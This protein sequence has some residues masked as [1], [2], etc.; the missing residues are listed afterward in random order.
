M[1][2]GTA[3]NHQEPICVEAHRL[4]H[5]RADAGY[6]GVRQREE[7]RGLEVE[8]Q[9][10]AAGTTAETEP[11]SEEARAKA[12]VRAKVEHPFLKVKRGFGYA[13]VRY[14]GWSIT[15]SVWP[16][17]GLGVNWRPDG[18]EVGQIRPWT[19]SQVQARRPRSKIR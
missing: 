12:P 10:A 7:N 3:S 1:E 2:P 6:Q 5:S 19:G 13:K 15:R 8:W 11:G 17:L 16:C 4:L 18:G 14:R 9:R